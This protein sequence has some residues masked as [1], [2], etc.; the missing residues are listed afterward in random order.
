MKEL[1][2][3]ELQ[4]AQ[5]PEFSMVSLLFETCIYLWRRRALNIGKTLQKP[6]LAA[7]ST[8]SPFLFSRHFHVISLFYLYFCI[9]HD[10]H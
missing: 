9:L 4:L 8:P 10:F 1:V 2:F 5:Q 6:T 7:P 3:H